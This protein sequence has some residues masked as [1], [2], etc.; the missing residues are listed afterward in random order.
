ME[1]NKV[2]LAALQE[3][4]EKMIT[5]EKKRREKALQFLDIVF[6]ALE[7]VAF[8]VWGDQEYPDKGAINIK[9]EN[10]CTDYYF[11]YRPHVGADVEPNGFYLAT[12]GINCWGGNVEELRGKEFWNAIQYIVEWIPIVVEDMENLEMCRQELLDRIIIK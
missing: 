6:E 2:D 1:K 10:E 8:D 11:R 3:S 5:G 7:K 9:R 4:V 12:R